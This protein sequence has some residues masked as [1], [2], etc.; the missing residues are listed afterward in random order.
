[1]LCIRYIS[2]FL[3]IF[4][5]AQ[6]RD[7]GVYK[8]TCCFLNEKRDKSVINDSYRSVSKMLAQLI[9]DHMIVDD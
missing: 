9:I 5:V 1:M 6:F 7:Y 8:Q 2:L 3:I 4:S